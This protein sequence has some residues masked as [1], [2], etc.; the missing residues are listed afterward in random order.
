M[1]S[2][3]RTLNNKTRK[4]TQIKFYKAMAVPTVTGGSEMRTITEKQKEKLRLQ[5]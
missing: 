1:C 5:K 2:T 4:K 3:I